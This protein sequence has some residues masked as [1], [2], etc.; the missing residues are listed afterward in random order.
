MIRRL[1]RGA[2]AEEVGRQQRVARRRAPARPW[3][4]RARSSGNR[5]AASSP[6]RRPRAHTKTLRSAPPSS[7]LHRSPSTTTAQVPH[8]AHYRG[9]GAV[10]RRGHAMRGARPRRRNRLRRR[11]RPPRDRR[12]RLRRSRPSGSSPTWPSTRTSR[13][14]SA[15]RHAAAGRARRR[16]QRRRLGAPAE[17]RARRRRSRRPS[18]SSS[19]RERIVYRI[20]KGSPL[21]GHVGVMTFAPDGSGARASTTTSASPRRSRASPRWCAPR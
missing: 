19:A 5:A 2:E 9:M 13:S 18:P 4:S 7:R 6:G 20:T 17:G 14:C 15:P 3:P 1:L 8:A 12:P 16:A 10:A 21:R 11:A